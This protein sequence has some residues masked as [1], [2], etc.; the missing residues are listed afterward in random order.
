[1]QPGA[2]GR[3]VMALPHTVAVDSFRTPAKTNA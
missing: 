3:T 2:D 1:V